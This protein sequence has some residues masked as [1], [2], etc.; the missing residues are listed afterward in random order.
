MG[1]DDAVEQYVT[2]VTL[3]ARALQHLAEAGLSQSRKA[4]MTALL[5]GILDRA[6][7]LEAL[8]T[9]TQDPSSFS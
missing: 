6:G 1:L 7:R 3:G 8:A 2:L 9:E 5:D 4:E